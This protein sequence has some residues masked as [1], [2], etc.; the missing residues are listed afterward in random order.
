MAT[1][2]PAA[3]PRVR[4]A[5]RALIVRDG[6]LLTTLMHDGNGDFYILPGGGQRHGEALAHT[7]AREC[8]EELGVE[9]E[10]GALAYVRDYI[11]RNHDFAAAITASIRSKR[12]FAA[13]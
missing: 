11:G 5:A 10:V 2:I 4:T 9:V 7:V 8:R 12:C 3:T 1:V 6:K 13:V